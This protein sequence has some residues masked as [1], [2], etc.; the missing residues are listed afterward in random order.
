MFKNKEGC[1]DQWQKHK[2]M[3]S[4]KKNSKNKAD[5]QKIKVGGNTRRR[6]DV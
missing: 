1:W 6:L 4:M 5:K 2:E 3:V